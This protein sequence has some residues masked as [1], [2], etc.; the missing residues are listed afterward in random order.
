MHSKITKISVGLFFLSFFSIILL[1]N[2]NAGLTG[3]IFAGDIVGVEATPK[4]T[5]ISALEKTGFVCATP[6][7]SF[8]LTPR[9]L[10]KQTETAFMIP[11]GVT[12]R[13]KQEL[14]NNHL[15][16]GEYS[17]KTT[18]TCIL[19]AVPPV[20]KTVVLSTVKWYGNVMKKSI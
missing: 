17:G 6:G 7:T 8:Q 10:K 2:A 1:E 20:E 11:A 5:E 18:V 3:Q 12:S 16:I 9:Y 19:E 14:Q 15:I 4:A 13:N